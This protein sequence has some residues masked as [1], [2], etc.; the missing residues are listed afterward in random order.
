MKKYFPFLLVILLSSMTYAQDLANSPLKIVDNEWIKTGECIERSPYNFVI[1]YEMNTHQFT[2]K[3]R[4]LDLSLERGDNFCVSATEQIS[5]SVL[6]DTHLGPYE[7]LEKA[8][9]YH[10]CDNYLRIMSPNATGSSD[11]SKLM[12]LLQDYYMETR[13]GVRFYVF[14]LESKRYSFAFKSERLEGDTFIETLDITSSP[15]E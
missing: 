8:I 10:K 4:E 14:E 13:S 6:E 3:M 7:I 5:M 15:V 12:I 2:L 11:L 9:S 1:L